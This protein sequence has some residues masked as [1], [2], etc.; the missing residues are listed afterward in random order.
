[1]MRRFAVLLALTA[2]RETAP[3]P[4]PVTSMTIAPPAPP[5]PPSA[6]AP[7][8]TSER[9]A[10]EPAISEARAIAIA[11]AAEG[12]FLGTWVKAERVGETWHVSAISKSAKPPVSYV[13]DAHTGEVLTAPKPRNA[14]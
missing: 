12:G 8:P 3:P 7:A 9:P 5:P 6:A 11:T 1:M 13:I 2:C 14:R 4:S 10:T